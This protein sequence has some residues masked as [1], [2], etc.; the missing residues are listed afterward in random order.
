MSTDL[1]QQSTPII[2]K[3]GK[4][5]ILATPIKFQAYSVFVVTQHLQSQ[6]LQWTQSDS[7]YSVS[8]IESLVVG[9]MGVGE[10]Q[11][12]Q[13]ATMAHPLTYTFMDAEKNP[14]FT[15]Q[16][17]ADSGNFKLQ[18]TV[19]AAGDYFEVTQESKAV[20]DA[21]TESTFSSTDA[22]VYMVEVKDSTNTP[23]CQLVRGEEEDIF[24]DLEPT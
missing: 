16:E 20:P 10:Q 15:V 23:V 21:W 4:G 5:G 13:T 22:V 24:L 19:D 18:I 9:E 12:C 17:I 11:F 3:G 1:P 14:I 8:Y 2:I 6:P 7:N